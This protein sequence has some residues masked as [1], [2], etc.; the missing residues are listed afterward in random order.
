MFLHQSFYESL[1]VCLKIL[2]AFWAFPTF[3]FSS[4]ATKRIYRFPG[5][6]ISRTIFSAVSGILHD[7]EQQYLV[8][9]FADR[10]STLGS[11]SSARR[12]HFPECVS[13][14]TRPVCREASSPPTCLPTFHL[15]PLSLSPET[16]GS[17]LTPPYA[18]LIP[19]I[20]ALLSEILPNPPCSLPFHH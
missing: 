18:L 6:E 13:A 1:S 9:V 10:S 11:L 12:G 2:I 20:A 16:S 15:R 14:S 4:L 17:S 3:D 8:D 7:D 5:P 19:S